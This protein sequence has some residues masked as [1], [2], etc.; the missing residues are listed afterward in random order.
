MYHWLKEQ[1]NYFKK[2]SERLQELAEEIEYDMTGV[3]SARME[4]AF[5]E[6]GEQHEVEEK[7]E[8]FER[9]INHGRT[10]RESSELAKDWAKLQIQHNKELEDDDY[11]PADRA[12][13]EMAI[14]SVESMLHV[15][16]SKTR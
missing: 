12:I 11:T 4:Q 3:M 8:D 10:F 13:T 14:K 1:S 9:R 16:W 7:A 6:L 5:C 15:D 2:I